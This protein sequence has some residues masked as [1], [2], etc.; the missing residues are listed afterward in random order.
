MVNIPTLR[1][2]RL[3]ASCSRHYVSISPDPNSN[4]MIDSQLDPATYNKGLGDKI[5]KIENDVKSIDNIRVIQIQL[6]NKK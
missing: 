2:V 1:S 3:L 6:Q 5:K 4:Y